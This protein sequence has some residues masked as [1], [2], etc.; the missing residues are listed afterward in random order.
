MGRPRKQPGPFDGNLLTSDPTR[1]ARNADLAAALGEVPSAKPTIGWVAAAF[2]VMAQL[3]EPRAALDVRIPTLIVAAGG[4]A[5]VDTRAAERFGQGLKGGGVIVIPG[6]RHRDPDGARCNTRAILRRLRRVHSG[7]ACPREGRAASP[8]RVSFTP[9]R[10]VSLPAH[11]RAGHP[12][13]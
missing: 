2:R 8:R 13:R 5:I 7:H 9:L 10:A 11:A 1:Y 3:Q 6:A 4:D 12:P